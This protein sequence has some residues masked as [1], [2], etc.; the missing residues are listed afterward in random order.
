ME[1]TSK[2]MGK[3]L[4][5]LAKTRKQI[6]TNCSTLTRVNPFHYNY[7]IEVHAKFS[8]DRILRRHNLKEYL[9][10]V[11]RLTFG[12]SKKKDDLYFLCTTQKSSIS[13]VKA[14]SCCCRLSNLNIIAESR[15]YENPCMSALCCSLSKPTLT[16]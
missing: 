5:Q 8:T 7:K 4:Y 13:A 9:T 16:S 11:C 15:S 1:K 3:F 14:S 10:N 2:V 6:S 12:G